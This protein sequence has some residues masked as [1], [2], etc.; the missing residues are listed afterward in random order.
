MADIAKMGRFAGVTS[1]ANFPLLTCSLGG[2]GLLFMAWFLV[3]EVTS[4]KYTRNI[5]KEI[6]MAAFSSIL[7]GVGSLFLLL[8]VGI[9]V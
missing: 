2:L 3:Y 8:W 9:Y 1:Q 4:N 7:L 5:V 6:S